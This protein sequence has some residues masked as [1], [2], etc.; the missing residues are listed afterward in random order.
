MD[1]ATAAENPAITYWPRLPNI[2]EHD[3]R[4]ASEGSINVK[5]NFLNA[6]V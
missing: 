4:N 2:A 3:N 6:R 5:K 1:Y